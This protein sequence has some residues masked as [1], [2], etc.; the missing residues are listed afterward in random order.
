MISPDA[1]STNFFF[2]FFLNFWV[3]LPSQVTKTV[4]SIW[5]FPGLS[6]LGGALTPCRVLIRCLRGRE[7]SGLRY[8]VLALQPARTAHRQEI[9]WRINNAWQFVIVWGAGEQSLA[10]T[11]YYT[12]TN[13]DTT[14]ITKP[15]TTALSGLFSVFSQSEPARELLNWF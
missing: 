11:L 4:Q 3:P 8:L 12:Q 13:S 7:L 10:L 1:R 9:I 2:S 5:T 6:G 15:L 14:N